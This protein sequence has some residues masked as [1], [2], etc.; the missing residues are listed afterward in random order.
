MLR[1]LAASDP[2][3]TVTEAHPLRALEKVEHQP[4]E[5]LAVV[6]LSNALRAIQDR[7]FLKTPKYTDQQGRAVREGAHPDILEFERRLVT[8]MRKQFVPLFCNSCVRG[9]HEQDA[10]L[11]RGVSK[12][13]GGQSPHNYGMAVDIIHGVKGWNIPKASWT[14]LGHVGKEIS[15]QSGIAVTWGG[16]WK[17]YDPAHWE[18]K[19]WKRLIQQQS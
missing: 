8:K 13:A 3:R 2:S 11:A 6:S 18:L 9:T 10:L 5:E 17:F 16:D 7:T 4:P 12:A 19:E 15:I 1:N 14:L